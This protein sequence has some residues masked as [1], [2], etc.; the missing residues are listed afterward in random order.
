[1]SYVGAKPYPIRD[2]GTGQSTAP[3]NGQLLIGNSGNYD[4]S[5]LT[6][7]SGISVTNSPG[8]ITI[9]STVAPPVLTP[10]FLARL[11]STQSNVTGDGTDYTPIIFD[12]V[13]GNV[14]LAYDNTTGL[15]TAPTTQI[16][17][18]SF[19]IDI[20][21]ILP[22]HTEC[23]FKITSSSGAVAYGFFGN[24]YVSNYSGELMLSQTAIM[25]LSASDTV[26][27][28][29]K[30]SNG[31]KVI[32]VYGD[33]SGSYNTWFAGYL[34]AG[35]NG[36][37]STLDA[38]VDG[39]GNTVVPT[40]G[41]ITLVNGTSVSSLTQSASHITLDVKGTTQYVLQVGNAS[42]SLNNLADGVGFAN[43]VLTS[44]GAGAEPQWTTLGSIVVWNAVAGTSQTMVPQ[45][46]YVNNNSGL[47]TFTLPATANFGDIIEIAGV[48][49][50]GWTIIENAGQ[51]IIVGDL[52]ST[53]TS[54]SVS[55]TKATDTI[56]LLCTAA[57][58]TFKA[59]SWAGN[60]T[61]V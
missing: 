23:S 26:Q 17:V 43:Q 60:L 61:V 52:T 15:F 51:S 18:F 35:N 2:G 12:T 30:I 16:Y 44:Q 29:L 28:S 8:H 10:V 40:G 4:V 5:N 34:L 27:V 24:P 19:G 1:M 47:T 6:A 33:A 25:A 55:S 49:A 57:N 37:T 11:S 9:S 38:V 14:G 20:Q 50:G 54:G 48:G 46:G 42:G 59:L 39:S 32:D 36:G 3:A 58:T 7:G 22:A 45:H 21:G 31:T 56:R 53:V 41:L 13:D